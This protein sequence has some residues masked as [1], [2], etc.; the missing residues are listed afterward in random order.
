MFK[1]TE[2]KLERS[3]QDKD[4]LHQVAR[5]PVNLRAP[6]IQCILARRIGRMFQSNLDECVCVCVNVMSLC[7]CVC[8]CVS[9]PVS[10]CQFVFCMS[11]C[12]FV[13][14]RARRIGRI[15][16][17]ICVGGCEISHCGL[18]TCISSCVLCVSVYA[19]ALF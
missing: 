10:V 4:L 17:P 18:C 2:G 11:V 13:C 16:S 3:K 6:G 7:A 1:N 5:G 14:H 15:I 8:I 12:V 19:R 9:E